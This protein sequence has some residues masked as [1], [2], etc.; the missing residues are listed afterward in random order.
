[1]R[2]PKNLEVARQAKLEPLSEI[3]ARMG[4]GEHLLEPYGEG[5]AMLDNHLYQ[6]NALGLE[7]HSITWRRVMDVNARALRNLVLRLGAKT[8]GVPRQGGF[9]ITAASEAMAILALS[10]SLRERFGRIVV[11]TD[12]RRGHRHRRERRDSG[13][14]L[15]GQPTGGRRTEVRRCSCPHAFLT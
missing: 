13:V 3:A 4:I 12:R 11:G 6:G 1:M 5:V 8:D 14:V 9:D 7:P 2:L 15:S 10:S